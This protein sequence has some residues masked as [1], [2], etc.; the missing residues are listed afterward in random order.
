MK[1]IVILLA[2]ICLTLPSISAE[3]SRQTDPITGTAA[4]AY[5]GTP[6]Y[7]NKKIS[8]WDNYTV[9]VYNTGANP[10]DF[11]IIAYPGNDTTGT[12]LECD[13]GVTECTVSAGGSG[14][15]LQVNKVTQVDVEVKSASGT[16]FVVLMT[17]YELN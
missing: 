10:L 9:W 17:G 3:V 5:P 2:L 7:E 15:S 12:F 11:R 13:T 4:A 16:D 14:I 6:Q 8:G 1:Y